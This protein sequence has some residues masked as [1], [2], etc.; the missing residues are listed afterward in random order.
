MHAQ[1]LLVPPLVHR[2]DCLAQV[3]YADGLNVVVLSKV[4]A[5]PVAVDKL[6][7][8]GMKRHHMVVIHVDLNE[9]LPVVMAAMHLG[10][11]KD[12]AVKPQMV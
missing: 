4:P 8:A 7:K 10:I 5:Q 9:T 11:V 12:K 1:Y 6:T 3:G 2:R